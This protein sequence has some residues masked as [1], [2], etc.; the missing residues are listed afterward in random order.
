MVT[1]RPLPTVLDA[2]RAFVAF[3]EFATESGRRATGPSTQTAWKVVSG[4]FALTMS[5]WDSRRNRCEQDL[6]H[7]FRSRCNR[8]KSEDGFLAKN[9]IRF[10]K[11]NGS[12]EKIKAQTQCD[13]ADAENV[14]EH[15]QESGNDDPLTARSA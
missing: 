9:A 3:G 4:L 8:Q 11:I 6:T 12:F 14:H 2:S 10:K 1:T 7:S 13:N 15:E 5:S